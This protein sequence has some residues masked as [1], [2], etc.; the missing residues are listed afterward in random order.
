[1]KK[2]IIGLLYLFSLTTNAQEMNKIQERINAL[3]VA[4]DQHDWEEVEQ[5]FS[6]TVILDYTSM[7]G[8][9]A[10]KL[11]PKQIVESWRSILPGFQ[12]THHQTGNFIIEE[13]GGRAEVY[14]YGTAFHY[15]ENDN[16]HMWTVVGSYDFDLE[17]ETDTWTISKMK[18][19]FKFQN[20]NPN[21]PQMAIQRLTTNETPISAGQRNKNL[22][23]QFFKSLEN[24][25][26]ETLIGLFAKDGKHINPY[27]SGLFPKGAN[28]ID[29]IRSYWTPV[30]PGFDQMQFP[31]EE[32]YA[33]EDP[34]RVYVKYKGVIKLKDDAGYYENEY[35]S[36]FKFN[37]KG[38]IVEYVEI[39]NPI[40]AAK[41]FG[42]LDKIK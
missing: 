12:Y 3:F 38:K 30:F 19:N 8:Q 42:L 5:C 25:D 36:T 28:G 10:A 32:L 16:D 35:Y 29:E 21:L 18:F 26:L 4:A 7:T 6:K 31:I 11:S 2:I 37:A 33:M 13:E 23:R 39:F 40:T 27:H 1:M 20:G 14:C 24:K 17:K 15:L 9:P 22:V 41:G 34:T